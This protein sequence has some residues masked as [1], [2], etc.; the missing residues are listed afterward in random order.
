[1]SLIETIKSSVLERPFNLVSSRYHRAPQHIF[2]S[3][4]LYIDRVQW[5]WW[6]WV[7]CQVYCIDVSGWPVIDN[8]AGHEH[9]SVLHTKHITAKRLTS[10][11]WLSINVHQ[12]TDVDSINFKPLVLW[13]INFHDDYPGRYSLGGLEFYSLGINFIAL[14]AVI[15]SR[16]CGALCSPT[17]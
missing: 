17:T 1:M 10:S 2:T 3:T 15:H 8:W 6:W 7:D 14:L 13:S 11:K 16:S 5:R 9:T 4:A 12:I